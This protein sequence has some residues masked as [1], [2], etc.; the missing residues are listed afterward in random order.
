M[1]GAGCRVQGVWRGVLELFFEEDASQADTL[2]ALLPLSRRAAKPS[3]IPGG[4][5][6][7][8]GRGV[9]YPFPRRESTL[10]HDPTSRTLTLG[11]NPRNPG[12]TRSSSRHPSVWG[13]GCRLQGGGA[14][15]ELFFEEDASE[16]DALLALLSF[17]RKVAKPSVGPSIRQICMLGRS[18]YSTDLY[19]TLFYND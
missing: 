17:S 16:A 14:R 15:L 7:I 18:I 6:C 10:P 11:Y 3:L 13:A 19:Q 8:P 1:Q 2:L 12:E 5:V 9:L 4:G